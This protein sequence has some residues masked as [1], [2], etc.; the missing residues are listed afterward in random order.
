M[1]STEGNQPP[2]PVSSNMFSVKSKDNQKDKLTANI[3][4][5]ACFFIYFRPASMYVLN[6]LKI[7]SCNRASMR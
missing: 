3:P 1:L 7:Y 6:R 5:V 2:L 4:S